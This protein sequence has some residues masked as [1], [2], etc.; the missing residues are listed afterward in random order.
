MNLWTEA[1][2][3]VSESK[4]DK[5]EYTGP[6]RNNKPKDSDE[7]EEEE[8]RDKSGDTTSDSEES[9]E[10]FSWYKPSMD[11]ETYFVFVNNNRKDFKKGE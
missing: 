3:C 8:S 6:M 4:L 2:R 7:E 1:H 5:D 10:D 11:P 9:D